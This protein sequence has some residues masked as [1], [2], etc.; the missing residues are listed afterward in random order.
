MVSGQ[1]A[2]LWRL[3]LYTAK[4]AQT[5]PPSIPVLSSR[6]PFNLGFLR[7]HR[8]LPASILNICFAL[9]AFPTLRTLRH[10]RMLSANSLPRGSVAKGDALSRSCHLRDFPPT[11][12][13]F[14]F[15]SVFLRDFLLS[16]PPPFSLCFPSSMYFT[17]NSY[18]LFLFWNS[19]QP[20][21]RLY[22]SPCDSDLHP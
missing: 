9:R 2:F 17:Y 4:N 6:Q 8:R 21:V 7:S 22:L 11:F 20:E 12:R 13:S 16:P 15:P 1:P 10:I 3:I 5:T 19:A 18:C 14:P